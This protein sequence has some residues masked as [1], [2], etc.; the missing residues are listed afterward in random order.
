MSIGV[1]APVGSMGAAL[2]AQFDLPLLE[3]AP[4]TG[5]YLVW[6]RERLA[7]AEAG[8]KARV[9]VDLLEGAQAHRRK[10]G[11]G[12]G[13]PV[14]KAVGL[15]AGNTP[16]VLDATAGLGR[17]AFVLATLGCTV[18]MLERNPVA[19]ALLADGM[20][21]G[22][23]DAA[24]AQIVA[25]MRLQ[26]QDARNWLPEHGQPA[27]YDVVYLDPM[28]PEPDKRARAK[29]D[30]HAFQ[31]LIGGDADADVLL[32]P[33]RR[34]ARQRVVVKR[35]RTAPWLAGVKPDFCFD[36]ESTRF[37]AYLPML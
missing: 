8:E 2:A 37:D 12:R 36:G 1:I 32:A 26:Q 10:F 3:S 27:S 21:R 4:A 14:A 18:D 23:E 20:R 16:T 33:A 15:K 24:I 29:K 13:Q 35:P 34:I 6:D 30:M 25:R 9:E 17:D 19:C 11:G 31:T 7:L 5:H 22:T 28:F